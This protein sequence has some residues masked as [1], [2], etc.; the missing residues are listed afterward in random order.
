MGCVAVSETLRITHYAAFMQ[1]SQREEHIN[2]YLRKRMFGEFKFYSETFVKGVDLWR[3]SKREK[4]RR[5]ERKEWRDLD[6]P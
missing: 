1:I 6:M 4:G 5:Q 2:V 3:Q